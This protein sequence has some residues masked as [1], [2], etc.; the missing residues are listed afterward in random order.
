MHK[1]MRVYT[2]YTPHDGRPN[3]PQ[4]LQM[5]TEIRVLASPAAR[6]CNGC[7]AAAVQRCQESPLSH[8]CHASVLVIEACKVL[9][10]RLVICPAGTPSGVDG[11]DESAAVSGCACSA[12]SQMHG[13]GLARVASDVWVVA[14]Q[15]QHIPSQRPPHMQACLN[16]AVPCQLMKHPHS[17]TLSDATAT[18]QGLTTRASSACPSVRCSSAASKCCGL[19]C[20]QCRWRLEPQLAACPQSP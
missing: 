17:P 3:T 16:A 4:K 14:D 8:H 15:Q 12:S 7:P 5:S 10:R 18:V 19:T 6:T 9:G 13:V 1:R 2:I 11:C 20:M